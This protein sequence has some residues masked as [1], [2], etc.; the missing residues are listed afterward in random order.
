M[1]N[2]ELLFPVPIALFNLEEEISENEL[3]FILNQEKTINS[4]NKTSANNYIL[5][6][7]ELV[8]LK[9]RLNECSTKY[10]KEVWS[11]DAPIEIT[12]SWINWT[13]PKEFHHKHNHAN[14]LYSGVFYV[15]VE[16][17]R[18]KIMFFN[19]VVS[20]LS[21]KYN[22]WNRWNSESWW[23]PVESNTVIMFPSYVT[24]MVETVSDESQKER[25]SL[26]FNTF[27]RKLGDNK[28]LT[29]LKL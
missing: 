15:D 22:E 28:G 25:I 14:S 13:K 8:N 2:L 4:G 10:A 18:D 19:P 24:H 26:A 6:E 3:H 23:L 17:S 21:P 11:T 5:N 29:E 16:S 7:A 20:C 12:Q 9:N 27:S 1:M